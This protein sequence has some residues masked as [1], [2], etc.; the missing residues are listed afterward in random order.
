MNDVTFKQAEKLIEEL[1]LILPVAEKIMKDS[2]KVKDINDSVSNSITNLN[3]TI[4]DFDKVLTSAVSNGFNDFESFE[5]KLNNNIKVMKNAI[6]KTEPTKKIN[7]AMAF[8]IGSLSTF[9]FLHFMGALN[10]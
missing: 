8:I 4:K 1:K 7:I 9:I 2:V 6:E 3:F 5:K 10:V